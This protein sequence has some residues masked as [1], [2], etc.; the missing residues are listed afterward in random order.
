MGTLLHNGV[1]AC[2]V[3]LG[4]AILAPCPLPVA[5]SGTLSCFLDLR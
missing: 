1:N 2:C 4:A 3:L 5:A